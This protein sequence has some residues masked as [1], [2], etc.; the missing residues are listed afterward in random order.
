LPSK[1]EYEKIFNE[2][3]GVSVKWSK[4]PK[5]DLA[6]LAILFSNPELLLKRFGYDEKIKSEAVKE[7]LFSAMKD[8]LK[9]YDGPVVKTLRD[10]LFSSK[11]KDKG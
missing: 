11:D 2:L 7:K 9:T 4:L 10:M 5:E 6:Q 3:L 1:E 8:F